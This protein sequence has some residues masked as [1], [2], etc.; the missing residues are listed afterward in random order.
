LQIVQ[1]G[2]TDK[3]PNVR[4]VSA[5][6]IGSIIRATE[7]GGRDG[8]ENNEGLGDGSAT[9]GALNEEAIAIME[10]QI[11]PALEKRVQEEEDIDVRYACQEAFDYLVAMK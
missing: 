1:R 2:L 6:G 5:K 9:A 10:S 7:E 11:R 8:G 3:V 4:M